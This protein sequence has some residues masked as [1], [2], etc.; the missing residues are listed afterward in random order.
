V[1]DVSNNYLDRTLLVDLGC[2]N[3][4]QTKS[5]ATFAMTICKYFNHAKYD[6][7]GIGESELNIDQSLLHNELTILKTKALLSNAK[8]IA[9]LQSHIR[10]Y[11]T[12]YIGTTKIVIVGLISTKTKSP[13]LGFVTSPNET[14]I[15]LQDVLK[16]ADIRICLFL[17]SDFPQDADW[18]DDFDYILGYESSIGSNKSMLY[19]K[20]NVRA[21]R[22]II[23]GRSITMVESGNGVSLQPIIHQL[24]MLEQISDDPIVALMVHQSEVDNMNLLAREVLN[25]SDNEAL[26]YAGAK[27]C[28]RCHPSEFNQW[29]STKHSRSYQ[30]LQPLNVPGTELAQSTN[31]DCLQ[32]HTTAFEK[33]SGG[34][35]KLLVTGVSCEECHGPAKRHVDHYLIVEGL[36]SYSDP[37]LNTIQES[38]IVRS[39]T[40]KTCIKCH[41]ALKSPTFEFTT[42]AKQILHIK[43]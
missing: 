1:S 40:R 10:K 18:I 43:E 32:C 36:E 3:A 33:F 37:E 2:F 25:A 28:E 9:P 14:L 4:P 11:V 23:G 24:P 38:Y 31:A 29:K 42:Y 12:K 6:A 8:L 30:A 21:S 26:G 15:E 5:N 13:L 19:P 17:S 7:I 22:N 34:E 16:T 41:D 27:I 35:R 20:F 39:P